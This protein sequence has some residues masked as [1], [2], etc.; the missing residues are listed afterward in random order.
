MA[1]NTEHTRLLRDARRTLGQEA[2]DK[3]LPGP[4]VVWISDHDTGC[5]AWIE[6]KQEGHET[7]RVWQGSIWYS[8]MYEFNDRDKHG[9]NEEARFCFPKI[10]EFFA[11]VLNAY[12]D[13]EANKVVNLEAQKQEADS[14]HAAEVAHYRELFDK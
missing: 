8:Q 12:T 4:F 14:K 3:L 9:W 10:T 2:I 7:I 5:Q 1:I 11:K 13:H 6:L